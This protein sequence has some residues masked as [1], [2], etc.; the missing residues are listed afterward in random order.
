MKAIVF[1][2]TS[3]YHNGCKKVME[4][5]HADL[6][7]NGYD[8]VQ[9]VYGNTMTPDFDPDKFEES[10]LVVINGEGSMHHDKPI[11]TLYLNLLK[12]AKER[13][14]KTALVNTVWQANPLSPEYKEVLQ[15]TYISVREVL[16]QQELE[17]DGI[18]SDVHLDLSYFVDVP[19]RHAPVR[20]LVI[21]KFFS[22]SDYRPKGVPTV[23][24]FKQDWDTIVNLLR[25][26]DWFLTGRHHEMYAACKARCPFSTLA[27]NTWKNEGLFRTAGVNIP[28]GE[29]KLPHRA[30]KGFVLECNKHRMEYEKLFNWMESQPKFS[31]A[32][33]L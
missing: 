7:K 1:N 10:D 8:V 31:L 20:P 5:L 12:M 22:Q 2:N 14:K 23:D 9:S 28:V 24:I 21:G 26:T 6:N 11:V 25:H 27:G 17:K 29:G 18:E 4:Y 30:M 19:E 13:G 32:N 3:R 16:S 15:D 33:K